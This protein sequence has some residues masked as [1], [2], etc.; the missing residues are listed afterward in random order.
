M[1]TT[2]STAIMA[3]RLSMAAETSPAALPPGWQLT[4]W[5]VGDMGGN[6]ALLAVRAGTQEYAIAIRGTLASFTLGALTGWLSDF[7]ALLEGDP[8]IPSDGGTPG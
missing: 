5:G 2:H 6:R 8:A 3:L 4:T 7:D 1:G